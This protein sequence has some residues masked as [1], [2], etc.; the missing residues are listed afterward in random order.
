MDGDVRRFASIGAFLDFAPLCVSATVLAA[1]PLRMRLL[2]CGVDL[3]MRRR[4][5]S[6][7]TVLTRTYKLRAMGQGISARIPDYPVT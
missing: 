7:P 1:F 5:D 4:F 2:S 3:T 6:S